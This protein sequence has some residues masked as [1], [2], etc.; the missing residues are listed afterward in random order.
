MRIVHDSILGGVLAA[1]AVGAAGAQAVAPPPPPPQ[2][3]SAPA[4]APLPM[5]AASRQNPTRNAAI[6]AS[7]NAKEPGNQRPEER[8]IPQISIPLKPRHG[9]AAAG[10]APAPAGVPGAVNDGAARCTAA[11]NAGERAACERGLAASGPVKPER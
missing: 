5:T 7:E 6:T 9:T 3:A 1:F 11:G 2:A 4:S 8:V 10:T